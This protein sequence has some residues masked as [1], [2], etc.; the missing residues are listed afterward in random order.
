MARISSLV[1]ACNSGSAAGARMKRVMS[2]A[3]RKT[4]APSTPAA[5]ADSVMEALA[6]RQAAASSCARRRA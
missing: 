1:S 2:G 3:S 5:S 4:S 6:R